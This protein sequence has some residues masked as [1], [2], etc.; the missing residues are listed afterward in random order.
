MTDRAQV[1][2]RLAELE[3]EV[4]DLRRRLESAP[5]PGREEL[6]R[7][8]DPSEHV[9]AGDRPADAGPVPD[10]GDPPEAAPEPPRPS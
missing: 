10:A 8:V 7:D 1:R 9:H 5:G 6:P 4:A 3:R 2:E